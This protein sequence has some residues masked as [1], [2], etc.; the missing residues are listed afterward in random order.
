MAT[1]T[2]LGG[3]EL[4]VVA[5]D[6]QRMMPSAVYFADDGSLATGREAERL[7][8]LAPE[9]FEP[10]PKRRIDD[11]ELLLGADVVAVQ[12]AITAVLARVRTAAA[13]MLDGRPP[14]RLHLTHPA[15]W[16][17]RRRGVLRAA[18]ADAGWTDP[19]ELVL[20]PEPI[21]AATNFRA[22]PGHELPEGDAVAVYDLGGGTFDA[23]VVQSTGSG[24][25]V[26]AEGGLSDVGGVDFDQLIWERI[27]RDIAARDP[28]YWQAMAVPQTAADRRASRSLREDV[29]AGKETLSRAAQ[30]EIPLPEPFSDLLLTRG[31]LENL[32]RAALNRTVASLR[33]TVTESGAEVSAIYLV[34][35]S[36]RIPLVAKMIADRTALVPVTQEDP[37]LAVAYGAAMVQAVTV[38]A[39][40]AVVGHDGAGGAPSPFAPEAA[41]I[42]SVPGAGGAS[43]V[44]GGGGGLIDSVPNFRSVQ[45]TGGD[46]PLGAAPPAGPGRLPGAV[47]PVRAGQRS[48][49]GELL[50][51]VPPAGAGERSGAGERLGAVPPAG[52]GEGQRL[53]AGERSGDAQRLGA[54]NAPD[55][56]AALPPIEPVPTPPG[57]QRALPWESPRPSP[58]PSPGDSAARSSAAAPLSAGAPPAVPSGASRS[59]VSASLPGGTLP[60]RPMTAGGRQAQPAPWQPAPGQRA[61]GGR[62][63]GA[64]ELGRVRPGRGVVGAADAAE[65]E[66]LEQARAQLAQ[67]FG[68][69]AGDKAAAADDSD[70]PDRQAGPAKRSRWIAVVVA[71]A[72]LLA[73][74]V[75]IVLLPP[76]VPGQPQPGGQQPAGQSQPV[77]QSPPAGDSPGAGQSAPAGQPTR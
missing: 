41:P 46:E 70:Q 74:A 59:A 28:G 67:L 16:G 51:A 39:G 53:G 27:G 64:P 3:T 77:G 17:R 22:L 75:A 34:G 68:Q 72:V 30:T 11:V 21:A 4:R 31:E 38:Q 58:S 45:R 29:R 7:A 6:G 44:G 8:R 69:S 32:I 65:P 50:G 15:Q 60:A 5:F 55:A 13:A 47:P 63:S 25:T 18:A 76:Q 33:R 35:G 10:N 62:A 49:A 61:P 73:A 9:R 42:A 2:A 14:A 26:L 48:G 56:G 43:S 12:Q 40:G 37:E 1:P 57:Q 19:D 24:L 52:A 71:L 36:S 66:P 20:I 23:A 54:V